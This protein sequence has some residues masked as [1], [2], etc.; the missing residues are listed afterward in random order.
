M[1][2]TSTRGSL[3]RDR[4]LDA[5]LALA[6]EAGLE[7]LTMRG[8]AARLGVE[9]MSL[10]NHVASK[11]ELLDG[12]V[13]RLVLAVDVRP[14]PGEAWADLLRRVSLA[15]RDV[16]IAH[17]MAFGLLTTRPLATGPALAH[18]RPLY[19]SLVEAGYE[20]PQVILMLNV[21]FTFLNGYLLAEVG[22]VPGHR[23]V[24]EPAG[25]AADPYMQE[26]VERVELPSL[27]ANFERAVD[28][29]LAGL[30]TMAPTA[31]R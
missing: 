20:I 24:P 18:V 19:E 31:A 5:A 23:D 1:A 26:V 15:Y 29:V 9:A 27:G 4:I 14:R 6:D 10:Y 16:A 11:A 12:L 25:V 28:L 21:F 3:S 13:E 7:G 17:P 30:R 8:L 2:R 22:T